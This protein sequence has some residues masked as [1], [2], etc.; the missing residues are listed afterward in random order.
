MTCHLFAVGKPKLAYVNLG[1]TEYLRRFPPSFQVDLHFLKQSTPESEATSFLESTPKM[2]RVLLDENGKSYTSRSFADQLLKWHEQQPLPIAFM[3]G[4]AEG[5]SPSLKQK[6]QHQIN[7][8]TLTFP[9]EMA[10]LI[11]VEQLYR[12]HSIHT[13]HPYHRD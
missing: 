10:L 11:C 4:S 6:I 5:H 12:A 7:L 1:L 2:R 3:I 13:R 8:S 9:H